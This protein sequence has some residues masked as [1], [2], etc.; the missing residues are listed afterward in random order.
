[1]SQL[2][3]RSNLAYTA[4]NPTCVRHASMPLLCDCLRV[5]APLRL[6]RN[7]TRRA[8]LLNLLRGL[9]SAADLHAF[10]CYPQT[11]TPTPLVS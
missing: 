3:L 11:R 8:A 10:G 4:C 5:S 6:N 9:K 1:M 7:L 2:P